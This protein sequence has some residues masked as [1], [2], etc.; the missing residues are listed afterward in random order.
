MKWSPKFMEMLIS[1]ED[2]TQLDCVKTILDVKDSF[3]VTTSI[4][5]MS[6]L[7]SIC[8]RSVFEIQ[9]CNVPD[10]RLRNKKKKLIT[11]VVNN[12]GSSK[13]YLAFY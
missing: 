8:Q 1:Y 9:K 13:V 3:D 6:L 2:D 4:S 7:H 12:K 11:N 5:L 10:W